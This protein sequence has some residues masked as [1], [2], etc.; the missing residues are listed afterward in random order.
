M[1]FQKTNALTDI[2]IGLKSTYRLR[3]T[4]VTFKCSFRTAQKTHSASVINQERASY[5]RGCSN[6]IC[7][8][9]RCLSTY[10]SAFP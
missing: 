8:R 7:S 2:S 6:A 10:R 3:L 1:N 5:C 9:R 4:L